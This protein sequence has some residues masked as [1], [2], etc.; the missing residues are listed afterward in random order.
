LYASAVAAFLAY[1]VL[2][3][4]AGFEDPGWL[5][6]I[7]ILAG[8]GA[9]AARAMRPRWSPG[10]IVGTVLVP[11]PVMLPVFVIAVGLS[12]GEDGIGLAAAG[13]YA[14]WEVP[15][16]LTAGAPAAIR[17]RAG[18]PGAQGDS[19][20]DD[21]A[22]A[23]DGRR[24]VTVV[25]EYPDTD[26][27]RSEARADR[28]RFAELGYKLIAVD[29]PART[30]PSIQLLYLV[31]PLPGLEVEEPTILATYRRTTDAAR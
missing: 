4:A 17:F 23:T 26:W 6:A 1:G 28:H 29:E 18:A 24:A 9:V 16:V 11:L 19:P 12:G 15:L 2:V 8:G 25:R 10:W 27:G 20:E 22:A 13:L 3:T 31:P 30:P 21:L 14:I 5:A 7:A